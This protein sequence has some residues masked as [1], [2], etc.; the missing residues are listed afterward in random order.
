[1]NRRCA[2]ALFA[3]FTGCGS[4][5]SSE[6]KPTTDASP[7][8]V[9]PETDGHVPSSPVA[10]LKPNECSGAQEAPLL[11][12]DG[13]WRCE[14]VGADTT[15]ATAEWPDTTSAEAP[16]VFVRPGASGTGT[17]D[18]P[19]SDL[20]AALAKSPRT[21]VL[22]RGKH[23]IAAPVKLTGTLTIVG[24]GANPDDTKGT[25][26]SVAAGTSPFAIEG[27]S[28]K[29]AFSRIAI[30][31]PTTGC[32]ATTAG[33]DATAGADVTLN[34]VLV[35]G[36]GDAIRATG[37][38][39][40]GAG[41]SALR[42]C[43]RG[44]ALL[45]SADGQIDKLLVRDG[46]QIGLVVENAHFSGSKGHVILNGARG[47]M[48]K[49]NSAGIASKLSIF[50]IQCNELTGLTV[51][52]A[53]VEGSHLTISDA[54][55]GGD[56]VLVRGAG[57]LT[58]DSTIASDAERGFGSQILINTRAGVVVSG[59]GSTFAANG[60]V[61]A[62]NSGPGAFIQDGASASISYGR[63]RRNVGV[64]VAAT[65][66][67][68]IVAI[69]CNELEASRAGSITTSAGTQALLGDAMS[70]S[71]GSKATTVMRNEISRNDGFAVLFVAST[72]NLTENTGT[73]NGFPVAGYDGSTFTQDDP[74]LLPGNAPAPTATP[75]VAKGQLPLP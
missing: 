30:V 51:D 42:G 19:V 24:A 16:I 70:L 38:K 39:V 57:K 64:G 74:S 25:V 12:G 33:I 29:V 9:G 50:S 18:S 21:I 14:V 65:S 2:I 46:K 8:D 10:D 60:A 4:S 35:A 58:L 67:S 17:K 26:F 68:S 66:G 15:A 56:G 63:V 54:R 6:T 31:Y 1:M 61:I 11:T 69:Q 37:A 28:A 55:G 13:G 62:S 23:S 52:G 34:D 22:S 45:A 73:C 44:L 48:F 71:E 40:H 41:V 36:A 49:G 47:A 75:T 32:A 20:A 3:L 72:G 7:A 59:K 43:N 27:A 5:S 53:E